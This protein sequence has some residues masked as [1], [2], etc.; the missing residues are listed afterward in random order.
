MEQESDVS[1]IYPNPFTN[2]LHVV[3]SGKARFQLQNALGQVLHQK[4]II[5]SELIYLKDNLP[6]EFITLRS[7]M[8]ISGRFIN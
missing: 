4:K 8:M 2:R 5:D 7:E 3:N 6:S 1:K